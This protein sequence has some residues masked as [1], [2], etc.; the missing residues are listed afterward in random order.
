MASSE[1]P[2]DRSPATYAGFAGMALIWGSTFLA[3]RIG[4]E[5]LPPIWGACVRL[6]LATLLYAAVV[7]LARIPWPRGAS[8]R[9]AAIYGLLNYGVSFALL[10]W[11]EVRVASGT[12]AIL[13]ATA[14]LSTAVAA[15]LFGVQRLDRS[16]IAGALLGLAGVALIFSGEL[17][18]GGPPAAL[19]AIFAA[20]TASSFG[21]VAL[22]RAP[23]Q[24]TWTLNGIGTA[25]GLL[26]CAPVSFALGEPH[27]LPRTLA[28]WGPVLYLVLAGNLGAYV[29][30]GWLI[31]KWK[32]T[33]VTA[34]TLVIPVIAVF[35]GALIR[36]EAPPAGTYAG[37]ALVL[38][39]VAMTLFGRRSA[40]A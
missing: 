31:G 9:A 3:I 21:S 1:V 27:A 20:A 22:K 12:T 2:E 6:V 16:T 40:T 15:A 13:Y 28:G 25:I 24:S 10:Y 33:R 38:A 11:G 23:H 36:H 4:N 29:L 35:L 30:F 14:P 19:L 17:A 18:H 7:Q 34:V 37:A 32:V 5:S 26:V 39:G 8:L